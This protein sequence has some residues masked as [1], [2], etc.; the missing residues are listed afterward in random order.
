M[1]GPATAVLH[2]GGAETSFNPAQGVRLGFGVT[3]AIGWW[4]HSVHLS[5]AYYRQMTTTTAVPV[6]PSKPPATQPMSLEDRDLLLATLD[7]CP[8][9]LDVAFMSL[10][11]CASFSMMQS[12]GQSGNHPGLEMGIGGSARLRGTW[13]WFFAEAQ[14]TAVRVSS[15]YERPSSSVRGL[16]SL[17][18]GVQFR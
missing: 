11:P 18:L 6:A 3:H 8:V 15:S 5:A 12:R 9:Q 17:S 1:S 14:A 4:K 13:N 16:Y 10:I 7:A 2:S